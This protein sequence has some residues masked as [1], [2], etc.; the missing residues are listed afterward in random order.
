MGFDVSVIRPFG[1]DVSVFRHFNQ[2]FLQNILSEKE[3]LKQ[4]LSIAIRI[5]IYKIFKI[6]HIFDKMY[7]LLTFHS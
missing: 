2:V 7:L 4:R 5:I 6:K 3:S 1:F